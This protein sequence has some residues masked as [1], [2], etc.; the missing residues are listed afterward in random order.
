MQI[1]VISKYNFKHIRMVVIKRLTIAIIGK[2]SERLT[3]SNVDE[4]MK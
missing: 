3:C 1:K 2:N 4:N